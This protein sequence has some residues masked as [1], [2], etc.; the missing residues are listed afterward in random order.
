VRIIACSGLG[1]D[2]DL[3]NP[4]GCPLNRFI[5]KPYTAAALLEALRDLLH[6]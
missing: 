4:S 1:T 2:R 6:G 3:F 5:P